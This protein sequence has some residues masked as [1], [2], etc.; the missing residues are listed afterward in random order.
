MEKAIKITSDGTNVTGTTADTLTT[1]VTI[2]ANT[3]TTG[4]ILRIESFN[5]FLGT[6]GTKQVRFYINTSA[7]LSGASLLA[8][9]PAA[10]AATKSIGIDSLMAIKSATN[11]RLKATNAQSYTFTGITSNGNSSVNIDW[12]AIQYIIVSIQLANTGD[13][14]F[15]SFLSIEKL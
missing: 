13:S 10:S 12:T 11:T 6:A 8:T 7:S 1:S 4:D 2:P 5:E 9:T 3:F 14:G 15:N